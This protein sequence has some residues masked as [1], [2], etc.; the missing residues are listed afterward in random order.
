M[1]DYNGD[2]ALAVSDSEWTHVAAE[3]AQ[4]DTAGSGLEKFRV[5]GYP[6]INRTRYMT[7]RAPMP[8]T[9]AAIGDY[10]D[11]DTVDSRVVSRLLAY[12]MA[13]LK[14]E[15]SA[16]FLQGILSLIP[17]NILQ[18]VYGGAVRGSQLQ[19]GIRQVFQ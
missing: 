18:Q 16:A 7:I 15:V 3:K 11:I 12:E 14:K 17:G 6:V 5:W 9:I 4:S 8:V 2:T 19:S 1:L 13:K 10:P